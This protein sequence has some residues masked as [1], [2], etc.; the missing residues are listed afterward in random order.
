MVLANDKDAAAEA[1]TKIMAGDSFDRV[2]AQYSVED[3]SRDERV[4]SRPITK[5][6]NPDYDQQAFALANVGDVSEPF[7]TSRGWMIVKLVERRPATVLPFEEAREDLQQGLKS[8]K[9]EERLNA[10]LEKWQGEVEIRIYE[11][12]LMKANLDETG[13]RPLSFS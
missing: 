10:L 13:K 4:G 11:D 8:I 9:N 2:S 1:Y 12:N 6:S 7:Q 5:G 3:I